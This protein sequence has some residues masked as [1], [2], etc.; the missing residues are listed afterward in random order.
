MIFNGESKKATITT[1][2]AFNDNKAETDKRNLDTIK[3]NADDLKNDD[4]K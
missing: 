4:E 2:A 3:F 1:V